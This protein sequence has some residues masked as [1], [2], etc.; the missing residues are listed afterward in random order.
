MLLTWFVSSL[1]P[2]ILDMAID[3]DFEGEVTH[4]SCTFIQARDDQFDWMQNS[5]KTPTKKTGPP[6]DHTRGTSKGI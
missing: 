2:L 4:P 5:G 1:F 3:C 6:V